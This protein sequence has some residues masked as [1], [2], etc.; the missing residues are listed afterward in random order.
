M[1]KILV[2]LLLGLS[3]CTYAQQTL[4]VEQLLNFKKVGIPAVS[5]DG[6]AMCYAVESTSMEK[7]KGN[8]DLFLNFT[9][10]KNT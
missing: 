1:K 3:L 9:S 2:S 5:P 8:K 4:S 7:N 10:D 6:V